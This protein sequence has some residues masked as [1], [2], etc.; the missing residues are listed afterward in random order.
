MRMQAT[1]HFRYKRKTGKKYLTK[2]LRRM[3]GVAAVVGGGVQTP[4]AEGV[5]VEMGLTSTSTHMFVAGVDW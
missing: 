2:Y 3:H 1:S 4:G 5:S